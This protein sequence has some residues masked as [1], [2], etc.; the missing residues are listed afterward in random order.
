MSFQ[1]RRRG[2]NPWS[3]H[4]DPTWGKKKKHFPLYPQIE[5]LGLRRRPGGWVLTDPD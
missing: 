3:R 5:G 2:F 4:L 1:C